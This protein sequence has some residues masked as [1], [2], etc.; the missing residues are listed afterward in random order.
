[1]ITNEEVGGLFLPSRD[2]VE[3]A[4]TALNLT[5]QE[6]DAEMFLGAVIDAARETSERTVIVSIPGEGGDKFRKGIASAL[7]IVIEYKDDIG[8][9]TAKEQDLLERLD[10]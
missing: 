4:L 1:M 6:P 9:D 2:D 8:S 3:T 5:G 10:S 7:G